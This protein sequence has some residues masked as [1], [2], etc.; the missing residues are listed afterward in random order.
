MLPRR[1]LG[2]DGPEVSAL[3][4]GAMVLEGYYGTVDENV[5]V[6]TVRRALELGIDFIDSAEAYGAGRNEELVGRALRGR[7]EQAFLATKF[8]IVTAPG[9]EGRERP[10]GWG[11]SLRLDARP[12][13]AR[14]ALDGSLARLG[15]AAVDLWYLHYPDPGTPIEES[16]GAMAEAVTAGKVR[17]LGL[18]NATPDEVRR[19]HAVHPLAAVQYECS[20]W[21]REAERELLPTLREL[22]IAL[23]PWSPLGSGF[24][25][26][27]VS[28]LTSNDFRLHNP[29]FAG[30]NLSANRDRFAPLWELA[31]ELG[32]TPAQL[33]LAWLLHR[34]EDVIPIPGTRKRERLEENAAAAA[35]TLGDDVLR[36]ID[37]LAPPGLAQGGTLLG[38]PYGAS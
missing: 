22:G 6:A 23:V 14:R 2:R 31:R 34:G 3:G 26:G 24:L 18:S 28:G 36:R 29:R 15:V 27:S 11:F 19:A 12:E 37:E 21:Q 32:A 33:A 35:L 7:R 20:L 1:R 17:Y 38:E 10:T 30:Q 25:T 8:G 16:I 13:T 5:A 4:Y 9:G